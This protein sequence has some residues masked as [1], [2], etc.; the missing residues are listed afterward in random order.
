MAVH[1][2]SSWLPL[3]VSMSLTAPTSA[4]LTLSAAHANT[5]S[6][7]NAKLIVRDC[8]EAPVFAWSQ[9]HGPAHCP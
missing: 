7:S 9:R 3:P 5:V 4:T 1:Y 6:S 2:L 8:I